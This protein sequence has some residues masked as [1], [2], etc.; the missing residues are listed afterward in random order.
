MTSVPEADLVERLRVGEHEAFQKVY[1]R[2]K[3]NVLGLVAAMLG[4]EHAAWDVLHDVFVS[5]ARNARNLAPDTNLKAYLL[6][7]GANRARDHLAK[8]KPS[9]LDCE[10]M[11]RIPSRGD[12]EPSSLAIG[13]EEAQRLWQEIATLP[14]E[15]RIVLAL[16]IF[17]GFTFK[18]IAE[19]EG[20]PENTAQSRYRY[21]IEKLRRKFQEE[22]ANEDRK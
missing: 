6:A 19:K 21:A 10:I 16:H 4:D 17:G 3:G 12:E 2:Y 13:K 1:E 5:L 20:V 22:A 8:C 7:A 11:D 14:Q 9:A 15:Q 18:E